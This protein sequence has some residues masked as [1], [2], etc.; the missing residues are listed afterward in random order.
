MTIQSNRRKNIILAIGLSLVGALFVWKLHDVTPLDSNQSAAL[1]LGYLLLFLGA[2]ALTFNEQVTTEFDRERQQVRQLAKN[3]FESRKRHIP[4]SD[5]ERIGV[6]RIGRPSSN[7]EFYFLTLILKNG[8]RLGTGHWV[9]SREEAYQQAQEIASF[10][11]CAVNDGKLPNPAMNSSNLAIAALTG[12]VIYAAYYRKAVGPW[13]PAMWFGSAPPIIILSSTWTT[14]A[15][16][17]RLR[18]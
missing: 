16:L 8:E 7:T 15:L 12:I 1:W 3:L 6:A 9:M 14:F 18:R 5:I 2:A 13:C 10:V 17:R 11:G 4:F